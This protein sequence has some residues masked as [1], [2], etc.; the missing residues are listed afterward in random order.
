MRDP[1]GVVAQFVQHQRVGLDAHAPVHHEDDD[2]E[3]FKGHGA[4]G[5]GHGTLDHDFSHVGRQ[6]TRRL[7]K[8]DE[9]Q[10]LGA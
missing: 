5:Q 1:V 4:S 6:N 2:L 3:V 9:A 10:A 8:T 7:E